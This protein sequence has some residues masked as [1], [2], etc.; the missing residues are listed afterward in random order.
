M[1]AIVIIAPDYDVAICNNFSQDA[2]VGVKL[3][4]LT[5]VTLISSS[6]IIVAICSQSSMYIIG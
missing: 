4:K 5:I 2:L 6:S 1:L 3:V